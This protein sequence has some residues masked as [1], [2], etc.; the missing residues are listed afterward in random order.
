M[1]ALLQP[2]TP[3]GVRIGLAGTA[4]VGVLYGAL[5]YAMNVDRPTARALLATSSAVAVA[6][7]A[8]GLARDGRRPR[9]AT[10]SVLSERLRYPMW[11]VALVIGASI[12]ALWHGRA[13]R[14][15]SASPLSRLS[16]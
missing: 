7:L 15:A 13:L 9:L 16:E 2:D 4:C 10:R 11:Q 12:T 6:C 8:L 14:V 3:L 5:V 1:E